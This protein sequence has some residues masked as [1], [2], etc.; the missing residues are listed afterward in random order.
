[1]IEIRNESAE[2]DDG[3]G[4]YENF[5]EVTYKGFETS[6]DW[7]MMVMKLHLEHGLPDCDIHFN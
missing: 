6:L 2:R 3:T 4:R 1:M 7:K 5:G